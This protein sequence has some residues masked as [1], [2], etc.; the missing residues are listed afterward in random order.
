MGN[1]TLGIYLDQFTHIVY[2]R[3]LMGPY[4][5]IYYELDV[6]HTRVV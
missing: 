5:I 4:K 3:P 1:A 2:I 6:K